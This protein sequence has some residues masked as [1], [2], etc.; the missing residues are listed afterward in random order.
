MLFKFDLSTNER[1]RNVTTDQSLAWKQQNQT[2]LMNAQT[3]L[4]N[5]YW[6]FLLE[7]FFSSQGGDLVQKAV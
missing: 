6:L 3:W 1:A 4:H 2:P 7:C 5:Y